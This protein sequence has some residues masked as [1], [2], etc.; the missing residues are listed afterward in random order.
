MGMEKGEKP[1]GYWLREA[2]RAITEAVNRHLEQHGLTRTHWQVLNT[3]HDRGEASR[4]SILQVLGNFLDESRLQEIL[5][6][7]FAK[8]WMQ[9]AAHPETGAAM[10]QMTEEGRAA[11]SN[12]L[13]TQQQTR[14]RLFEGVTREEYD[15]LIKVLKQVVKN[16]SL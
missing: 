13:A 3:V 10:V 8:Q 9:P 7:F 16:A 5:G 12:I 1:I 2:D 15:T 6:D 14:L 11:F 4:E